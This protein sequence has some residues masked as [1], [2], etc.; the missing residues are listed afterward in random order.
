MHRL[1]QQVQRDLLLGLGVASMA[2]AAGG[3]SNTPA[4]FEQLWGGC[5]NAVRGMFRFEQNVHWT[6]SH[7]YS[8]AAHA[9]SVL[10]MKCENAECV[11]DAA[12][13]AHTLYQVC[14]NR[15]EYEA[16]EQWAQESLAMKRQVHGK[17]AVHMDIAVSLHALGTV[18][19]SMGD[20]KGARAYHVQSLAMA[21]QVHGEEAV[22]ADIAASLHALGNLCDSMGDYKG[23]R[24]YYVQSLAMARQ[25]HGKEAVHADIAVSLHALGTVCDSM[26]DYK[27]ARSYYVQSLA[28]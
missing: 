13:V 12:A 16:G 24:A 6:W 21:R 17:E 11:E 10:R 5:V 18:C 1:V 8:M 20:Y 28:M 14:D 27:G 23:A 7:S 4:G 22:H 9:Q 19:D 26:G 2:D 25:V 3:G 15:S